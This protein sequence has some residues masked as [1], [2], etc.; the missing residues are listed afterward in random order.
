[1]NSFLQKRTEEDEKVNG[2]LEHTLQELQ[3]WRRVSLL[4][5]E[6]CACCCCCFVVGGSDVCLVKSFWFWFH[7]RHP[8][9]SPSGAFPIYWY[10]TSVPAPWTEANVSRS[11]G[12][13]TNLRL[14]DAT[15]SSFLIGQYALGP[16][17]GFRREQY[18]KSYIKPPSLSTPPPPPWIFAFAYNLRMQHV[19]N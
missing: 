1:M 10:F 2:E 3:R 7:C 18:R 15:A 13:V 11:D 6:P 5:V 17:R 8:M 16:L 12:L 14:A 9:A 19:A 4:I